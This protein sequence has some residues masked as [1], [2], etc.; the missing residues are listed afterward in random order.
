MFIDQR[1]D[2]G[3]IGAEGIDAF[4]DEC[5][6]GI[7]APLVG[8]I[9]VGLDEDPDFATQG[10]VLGAVAGFK[11]VAFPDRVIAVEV[12]VGKDRDIAL[13][14]FGGDDGH[15]LLLQPVRRIAIDGWVVRQSVGHVV[16]M[17]RAIGR[18]SIDQHIGIPGIEQADQRSNF[19][20]IE[21]DEVS[22][23]ILSER[24]FASSH[25][26]RG[27]FLARSV[28]GP[29]PLVSVGVEVR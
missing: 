16:A 14:H 22:V 5:V 3:C 10:H 19:L 18:V 15:E 4:F 8:R 7:D 9:G 28:H 6:G 12:A 20:G 23:E 25:P 2:F 29:D 13:L 1:T 27:A 26:Q 11:A 21:F 24:I 17:E